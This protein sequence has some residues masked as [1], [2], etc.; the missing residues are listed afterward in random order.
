MINVDFPDP[1]RIKHLLNRYA[2]VRLDVSLEHLPA[3]DRLAL[4]KLIEAAAWID[5]IY[6]K[7]RSEEGWPL[8]TLVSTRRGDGSAELE[9]LLDVNFGPWDNF[10][11]DRPFWGHTEKPAGGNLY[12]PDMTRE[13]FDDYLTAHPEDR[14]ALLSHTTL[15]RRRGHRL[16]AIPYTEAFREELIN[17]AKNLSEASG[18]VSDNRFRDFLQA[19]AKA[20]ASGS[21]RE[22]ETLWIHA[23]QSPIDIAIGPYEVYEDALLGIKTAYEATVMVRHPMSERLA[24]FESVAAELEP[25]LP[26]AVAPPQSQRKFIIGVYDVIYV[27]GMTNMGGKAIAAT[28]PND[29]HI[30]TEV[31]ARL[32]L[33]RNVIA[34]KFAP[35]LKRIGERVLCGA[36][37][38]LLREEAFLYHTL[39]HEMAH[40]LS[41]CFVAEGEQTI[42]E[43]LRER[44]SAVEECR[45]DLLGMVFLDLLA[46]RGFIEG[47]LS[48]AAAATFV[49]NNV[50]TLRFG[51]S[52]DYSRGA[53]VILSHLLKKGTLKTQADQR[54]VLDLEGVHRSVAELAAIVQDIVT[55][56]DYAAAGR[57]LEELGAIPGEIQRL[58]PRLTDIPTDLEF[59]R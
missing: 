25:R 44:Y 27:A 14:A 24:T 58:L 9:R 4:P 50:R 18:L 20:L 19:R 46:S 23:A 12:P 13:E 56:G 5:R 11:N 22:S 3:G 37:R 39:L 54:L 26:G 6:W 16:V 53:A 45:A 8:K 49:A 55:R 17:V 31:G 38:S 10:D 32:L 15:V 42:N 48:A 43:A 52:D 59:I 35:I 51:A 36:Q 21:L 40:A 41:A 33:F 2:P 28:L 7:Q 47:A 29:E 30:R 1:L 57:L 34:A